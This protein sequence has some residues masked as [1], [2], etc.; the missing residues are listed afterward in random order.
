MCENNVLSQ[1]DWNRERRRYEHK[2]W[3]GYSEPRIKIDIEKYIEE[4]KNMEKNRLKVFVI[5]HPYYRKKIRQV[6][7]S[8][9]YMCISSTDTSIE[10]NDDSKLIVHFECNRCTPYNEVYWVTDFGITGLAL[11]SEVRCNHCS[12]Y[13]LSDYL[14]PTI[15]KE[16]YDFGFMY[17]HGKNTITVFS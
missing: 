8:L 13:I 14:F 2:N 5:H 6:A 9:G 7:E 11:G 17:V 10:M 12:N 1:M 4:V 15:E 16:R 3:E